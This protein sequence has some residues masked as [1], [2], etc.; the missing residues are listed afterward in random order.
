MN[1]HIPW[2]R[3]LIDA[4]PTIVRM[5]R[6]SAQSRTVT[7]QPSSFSAVYDAVY[8]PLPSLVCSSRLTGLLFARAPAPTLS[9][10]ITSTSNLCINT[11]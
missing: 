9:Q 8:E 6:P 2:Q 1:P 4:N 5:L 10:L 3:V 7:H 11:H